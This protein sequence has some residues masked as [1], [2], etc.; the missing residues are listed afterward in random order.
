MTSLHSG[1][2]SALPAITIPAS[3]YDR[4]TAIAEQAPPA[5][6]DY[7]QRELAR[8]A[9]VQDAEFDPDTARIGSRVVYRDETSGQTLT[10]TRFTPYV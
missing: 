5:V 7:L 4:L 6:E 1:R 9:I 10:V 2:D 3:H 8:A